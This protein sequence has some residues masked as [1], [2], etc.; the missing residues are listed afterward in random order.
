[1]GASEKVEAALHGCSTCGGTGTVR[2]DETGTTTRLE[3]LC[4]NH[5]PPPADPRVQL[6]P[7]RIAYQDLLAERDG[8]RTA[9]ERLIEERD[10][11]EADA[12]S[13][14]ARL[15]QIVGSVQVYRACAGCDEVG[16]SCRAVGCPGSRP[17]AA[18]GGD[19]T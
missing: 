2:W 12:A 11:A 9:V 19:P 7:I 6:V 18:E 14:H 8:L 17:A 10:A 16:D 5:L 13:A 4:P 1:M 15:T 3:W